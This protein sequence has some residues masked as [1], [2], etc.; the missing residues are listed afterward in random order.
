MKRNP[1]ER[2]VTVHSH[3]CSLF[4]DLY[5]FFL[6]LFQKFQFTVYCDHDCESYFQIRK[7]FSLSIFHACFFRVNEMLSV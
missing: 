4:K 2:H 5:I 6:K 7:I 3:S 1:F